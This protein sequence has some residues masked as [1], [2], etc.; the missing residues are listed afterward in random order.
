[1][2]TCL[3]VL[4]YTCILK[5]L[6]Y[7]FLWQFYHFTLRC[8]VHFELFLCRVRFRSI[9]LLIIVVAPV[10]FVELAVFF[11]MQVFYIAVKMRLPPLCGFLSGPLLESTG[12][13]VCLCI[14]A[15]LPL[16]LQVCSIIW[17]HVVG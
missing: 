12:L 7:F 2:K 5:T 10:P 13:D 11:L 8:L 9:F 4:A 15:K 3:E 6:L 16:S 1:M 14:S 17:G